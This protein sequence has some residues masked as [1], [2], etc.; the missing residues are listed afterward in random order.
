MDSLV[1]SI[2]NSLD[3][4]TGTHKS[5]IQKNDGNFSDD[6][7]N[8]PEEPCPSN[9]IE[10]KVENRRPLVADLLSK[11]ENLIVNDN[12]SDYKASG[13]KKSTKHKQLP[14]LD[15]LGRA[16]VT[17]YSL[18][19]YVKLLP[20]NHG[21]TVASRLYRVVNDF[22]C[23]F[24]RFKYGSCYCHD[25]F[26]SGFSLA[27]K[28]ARKFLNLA[29]PH[30][31]NSRKNIAEGRGVVYLSPGLPYT[32]L[33]EFFNTEFGS[34]HVQWIPAMITPF[35]NVDSRLDVAALEKI[36]EQDVGQNNL[37]PVLVVAVVGSFLFGHNDLV[38]KLLELRDRY[39][40]WLHL[41]GLNL[42][43]LASGEPQTHLL[44]VL[45]AANSVS[46]P[47][48][49]WI[50][51][52]A[53]PYL[54]LYKNDSNEFK[55]GEESEV[56]KSQLTL[57]NHTTFRLYLETLPWWIVTTELGFDLMRKRI[58]DA[59][60]ISTL[61][62]KYLTKYNQVEV[63][64][65]GSSPIDV[66]NRI[67]KKTIMP[68]LVLTFK[69]SPPVLK[70]KPKNLLAECYLD[71]QYLDQ[72]NIWLGQGVAHECSFLNLQ[73]VDLSP[74][75]LGTAIRYCPLETVAHFHCTLDKMAKFNKRLEQMI[76]ILDTTVHAKLKLP[77]M[78]KNRPELTIVRCPK[79]AG[80]TGIV[81]VPSMMRNTTKSDEE[82]ITDSP[83]SVSSVNFEGMTEKQIEQVS[84]LNIELL[85][86]LKTKDSAFSLGESEEGLKCIR[87]GMLA[88]EKDLTE[89][90]NL[91]SQKGKEI[92]ESSQYLESLAEIVK[93]G[94]EAANEDLKK[95][96]ESKLMNEG[97][98]RQVPLVGSMLNWWSPLP[99]QQVNIKGRAFDLVTGRI[100]STDSVFKHKSASD[101]EKTDGSTNSEMDEE[102]GGDDETD[103]TTP[104]T[105]Q[106]IEVN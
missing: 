53:L 17:S 101:R 75:K 58:D 72:L 14:H 52:P 42:A 99:K 44:G 33:S 31:A 30:D 13:D 27:F 36:L 68:P 78:I 24:F 77:A 47:L 104:D 9:E 32:D 43:A 51:V 59:Y 81:Y 84:H 12:E 49:S 103:E 19:S 21:T 105:S 92:E 61:T 46:V 67:E 15:E 79:W 10:A 86:V 90:L 55:N 34:C 87:F 88:D 11:L 5:S 22:I 4:L 83:K 57:I 2:E 3:M 28:Q 80:V 45:Q 85:R 25:D 48:G 94:I 82:A 64:G 38:S 63:L 16:V 65:L 50:G 96:N 69:Y 70:S 1:Q 62:L 56:E 102:D 37:T 18:Q 98:L 54:T 29:P 23:K 93:Q 35:V 89:L 95:E 97:V 106:E 60:S 6:S 66:L 8:I 74:D 40:F 73:L 100:I 20:R 76:T 91:V 26:Y 7:S 41:V 39:G 71:Q